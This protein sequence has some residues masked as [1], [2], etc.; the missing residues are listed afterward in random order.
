MRWLAGL[1]LLLSLT[2]V[3]G[4]ARRPAAAKPPQRLAIQAAGAVAFDRI[5]GRHWQRAVQGPATWAQA[6]NACQKNAAGLPGTGWRLP[7]VRELDDLLA[8]RPHQPMLDDAFAGSPTGM[9]WTATPIG[10]VM[11]QVSVEL[12]GPQ[13]AANV[14]SLFY[15]RCAQ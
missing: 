7:N 2:A 10:S 15:Y 12:A 5:S 13:A 11:W 9:Y 1:L 8:M 3:V 14:Q 6:N 4:A